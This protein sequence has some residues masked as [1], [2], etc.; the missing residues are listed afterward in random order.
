[1]IFSQGIEYQVIPKSSKAI[2]NHIPPPDQPTQTDQLSKGNATRTPVDSASDRKRTWTIGDILK[3]TEGYLKEKGIES[4]RLDGELLMTHILKVN[5][6]YLYTNYDRPLTPQERAEFRKLIVKRA[7]G[8]PVAYLTGKKEF[9]SREYLVDSRVLVPRPET[10]FLVEEAVQELKKLQAYT[11]SP[12]IADVGTGSGCIA[13]S[14]AEEVKQAKVLAIDISDDAIEVASLN[15]ESARVGDRVT[16]TKGD[17]LA[18]VPGE[19]LDMVVSNPPYI[20]DLMGSVPS[21]QGQQGQ[22][23]QHQSDPAYLAAAHQWVLLH[24]PTISLL[25]GPDGLD[26]YRRLLPQG[27]RAL[28]HDRCCMLEIGMRQLESVKA[29]GMAAGFEF[30]SSVND[31]AG[32]PRVLVFKKPNPAGCI[33][34]RL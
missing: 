33:S 34:L 19:S 18:A 1:M 16:V 31:L 22:Q 25:A 2:G 8:E 11:E 12:A 7:N 28:K 23:G 13:I 15:V 32:I 29:L 9:W 21:Q 14:I 24:E 30:I 4:P 27:L 17:L 10:E 20:P 3:W 6:L 5:R 26:V